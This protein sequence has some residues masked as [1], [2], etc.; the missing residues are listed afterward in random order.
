MG[1]VE[2]R[3]EA[4]AGART[5]VGELLMRHGPAVWPFPGAAH[6]D[7]PSTVGD[8][9]ASVRYNVLWLLQTQPNQS[10]QAGNLSKR[11]YYC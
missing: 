11:N 6:P 7:S 2:T 4:G 3:G 10:S 1:G 9:D 5:F 8:E